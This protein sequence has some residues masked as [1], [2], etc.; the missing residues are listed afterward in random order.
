MADTA[1]AGVAEDYETIRAERD[2]LRARLAASTHDHQ[3]RHR[4]RSA[5]AAALV[6]LAFVAFLAAMP[7]LWANRNLLDTERFVSRV[8]PLVDEP[9]VQGVLTN[10]LTEQVMLLVDPRALFEQVLPE[11]GQVLAVPLTNAVEGFVRDRVAS[12]V[13]SDAFERIWVGAASLAHLAAINVLEG[14]SEAVVASDGRVTLNLVP[15]VDAVLARITSASPEILGREV[16]LP[17]VSVDDVPEAAIQR[18]EAAF[19]VELDDDF[20]QFTVYDEGTLSSAQRGLDVFSRVV[21][22][23]LPLAVLAAGLALW[24][25]TRRRRTLLEL[26]AAAALAAVL[27]RRLIFGLEDEVVALARPGEGQRAVAVTLDS[28]LTPLTTFAAWTVAVAAV[29]AAAALVTGPYAWAVASRA[30]VASLARTVAASGEGRADRATQAWLHERRE[31]LTVLAAGV[32]VV[33]LW[34]LDLSWFWSLVVIAVVGAII[35]VVL[36][37]GPVDRADPDGGTDGTS[38]LAPR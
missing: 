17:E 22:L 7:G 18:I 28:F 37:V 32:G 34:G 36:R 24:V 35:A 31:L 3:R 30:R 29:V 21:V 9:D 38:S 11:R 6:A 27:V 15:A 2:E 4:A 12:F 25:S 10:R 20:G 19:D 1:T 16:D 33:A 26:A 8:A 5:G 14:D 23:V 13:A